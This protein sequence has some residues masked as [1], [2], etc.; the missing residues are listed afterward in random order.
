VKVVY[1]PVRR[2]REE[3]GLLT[4]NVTYTYKQVTEI[5]NS[6]DEPAVIT[7]VDQ[8]PKSQDEKLKVTLV[9]PNIPK[10]KQGAPPPNPRLNTQNNVEWRLELKAGET[11]TVTIQYTVEFPAN[12]K[13]EGL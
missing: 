9:E 2:F 5:L 10:Q 6:R 3:G 7:F 8:V 1:K 4:K 11:R 13:V 12:K